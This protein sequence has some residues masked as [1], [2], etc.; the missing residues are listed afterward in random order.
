MKNSLTKTVIN[1][2]HFVTF[3][4]LTAI[5][6]MGGRGAINFGSYQHFVTDNIFGIYLVLIALLSL[7]ASVMIV[8]TEW[9]FSDNKTKSQM[10]TL[11][12][13]VESLL[14]IYAGIEI[15]EVSERLFGPIC[16]NI[17][18]LSLLLSLLFL[19]D[20]SKNK[21]AVKLELDVKSFLKIPRFKT[22][23]KSALFVVIAM[24]FGSHQSYFGTS[25]FGMFVGWSVGNTMIAKQYPLMHAIR[26]GQG[27]EVHRLVQEGYSINGKRYLNGKC[28][29]TP[30]ELAVM[31]RTGLMRGRHPNIAQYLIANGAKMETCNKHPVYEMITRTTNNKIEEYFLEEGLTD[32]NQKYGGDY[33]LNLALKRCLN[34]SR[35]SWTASRIRLYLKYGADPNIDNGKPLYI[36]AKRNCVNA[37]RIL[38]ENGAKTDMKYENDQTI[39]QLIQ[40]GGWKKPEGHY[41]EFSDDLIEVLEGRE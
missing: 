27:D 4:L 10:G 23:L 17:G 20:A 6:Y 36:A 3:L 15:V 7:I 1:L 32:P 22:L 29:G 38:I 2:C 39:L 25:F 37:T 30:L 19:R 13:F 34:V 8:S 14:L 9:V 35:E 41:S 18:I 26:E 5:V 24:L 21:E 33:P 11:Y 40:D 28:Y 31:Q 16:L 12:L